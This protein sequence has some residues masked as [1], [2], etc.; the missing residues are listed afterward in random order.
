MSYS[1]IKE[2]ILASIPIESYIGQY[3]KLKK[4]GQSLIGLCPFHSEKSPSFHVTPDKGF[5][6][7]FGCGKSGNIFR[8][9]MERESLNFP[10]AIE[11]LARFANINIDKNKRGGTNKDFLHKEKMYEINEKA[12]HFFQEYLQRPEAQYAKS[13]LLKRGIDEKTQGFFKIGA[14]PPSWNWLKDKLLHLNIQEN[15]LLQLGL[16]KKQEQGKKESYDFFRDRI[17]FPILSLEKKIVG[18]GGRVIPE[19]PAI[20]SS[21]IENSSTISIAKY[22]NSADSNI[23][24][25]GKLLYGLAEN[26]SEIR[27]KKQIIIV[28]GYLD[29]IGLYQ[30]GIRNVVAPLGT[31][32]NKEQLQALSLYA[33]EFIFMLDGDEAGI[34]ATLRAYLASLSIPDSKISICLLPQNTDP[35]DLTRNQSDEQIKIFLEHK[36]EATSFFLIESLQ[37]LKGFEFFGKL[38]GLDFALKLKAYYKGELQEYLPQGI[39]KRGALFNL[40]KNLENINNDTNL[41]ILLETVAR[42]LKLNSNELYQEW[43]QQKNTFPTI[44]NSQ[45]LNPSVRPQ[46]NKI[47]EN[48][49]QLNYSSNKK[50]F[51]STSPIE[52]TSRFQAKLI[53]CERHLLTELL[54]F[55][56]LM[57]FFYEDFKKMKFEDLHSEHLW[58]HLESRYLLGSTWSSG[59]LSEWELDDETQNV[60]ITLIMNG[61]SQGREEAFKKN[62]QIMHDYFLKY[63]IIK[64]EKSIEE[65]SLQILVADSID[66]PRLIE[67]KG[68]LIKELTL[69]KD[70]WRSF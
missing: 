36:I 13:Y 25:K 35:F 39:E 55:P 12:S 61:P 50:S 8:F 63:S 23:F 64:I 14:S 70:K 48:S 5:Y 21:R 9:V 60:F 69:L 6:H 32:L 67:N 66:K 30:V 44:N 2:R 22:I 16:L 1:D 37:P 24:K 33:K 45:N 43:I 15:D 11:L 3:V 17:L 46:E 40:Y 54:F 68:S 26:L 28:E 49:S 27:L 10:Q 19:N 20:K 47:L 7:C 57:D 52:K 34:K 4:V 65:L 38:Q 18:F 29:V 41:R 62:E 59:R 58:R 42:I 56:S 51:I 31:A 53:I